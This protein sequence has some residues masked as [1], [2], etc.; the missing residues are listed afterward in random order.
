MYRCTHRFLQL[1][2]DESF[3]REDIPAQLSTY[4]GMRTVLFCQN[5]KKVLKLSVLFF[6]FDPSQNL[7]IPA[8]V[9]SVSRWPGAEVVPALDDAPAQG[10]SSRRQTPW[11]RSPPSRVAR[12]SRSSAR[13]CATCARALLRAVA[14]VR[15]CVCVCVRFV[16]L[17]ILLV[18]C[19]CY[20]LTHARGTRV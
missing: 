6:P 5:P 9:A 18:F 14:R 2:H 12:S 15:V 1:A 3:G 7:V 20:F 10:R 4:L 8:R 11:R 17:N 19:V 13:R 16:V